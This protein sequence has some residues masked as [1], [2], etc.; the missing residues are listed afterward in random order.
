MLIN[1]INKISLKRLSWQLASLLHVF[2]PLLSLQTACPFV[3][4]NKASFNVFL[5]FE[6]RGPK[7]IRKNAFSR[8]L[9]TDWPLSLASAKPRA[10]QRQE[11]SGTVFRNYLW[12]ASKLLQYRSHQPIATFSLSHAPVRAPTALGMIFGATWLH[13]RLAYQ[14]AFPPD[15][16]C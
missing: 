8:C 2:L 1:W 5:F 11:K 15:L 12:G 13:S 14:F 7:S 16:S 3:V 10:K 4:L 9:A 6:S